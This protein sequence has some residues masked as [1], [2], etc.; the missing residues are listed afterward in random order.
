MVKELTPWDMD[1]L[2]PFQPA[3][4]SGFKTERYATGLEEGFS[5]AQNI[6]DGTIR[7]LVCQDIGGDHQVIESLKTK[8]VGVTF[9]HILLPI[10]IA[11]YRYHNDLYQIMV[12]A[13]TGEVVG[14][15]PYSIWKILLL[16]MAIML[17]VVTIAFTA[18]R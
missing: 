14:R 2:T 10:W 3:Y 12:N 13:R 18:A 11:S 16:V 4:L 17:A 6:M 15:R 1:V 8:H 9:K 5:Y 7:N